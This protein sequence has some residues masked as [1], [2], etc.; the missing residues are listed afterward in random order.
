MNTV[1]L[2]IVIGLVCLGAELLIGVH[3]GFDLVLVGSC[4]ILGGLLARLSELLKLGFPSETVAAVSTAIF[5]IL[6]VVLGRRYLKQKL[7]STLHRSNVDKLIGSQGL[8]T[9]AVSPDQPGKIVLEHETWL[10]RSKETL[11]VGSKAEVVRIEGI[12]LW[13]KSV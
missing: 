10:A 8:M 4:F 6:Y 3:A 1:T 11:T 5:C 7:L 13:V 2:F 12:S 9:E